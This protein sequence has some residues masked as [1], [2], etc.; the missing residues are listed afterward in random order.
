MQVFT[1]KIFTSKETQISES[2]NEFT[3][4]MAKSIRIDD[5]MN[6]LHTVIQ[7][8]IGLKKV[9]MCLYNGESFTIVHSNSPL[10]NNSINLNL[11][12]PLIRFFNT[13]DQCLFMRDFRRT[14]GYKSMWEKEKSELDNLSIECFYPLKDGDK[15]IGIIFLTA[16]ANNHRFTYN[17][18]N[19]LTSVSSI[20][21]IA[22]NNSRLYE[23]VLYEAN[24]DSLTGLLNRKRFFEVLNE[25]Y[26]KNK[27][28]SLALVIVNVDDFKLYNQLYGN[29]EGDKALQQIA[30]IIEATVGYDGHV[31]RYGGK[32]FAIILPRYDC[33]SA[34]NIANSIKNQILE[35]NKFT[36]NHSLKAIT[37]SVG[38]S[39]IP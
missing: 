3:A 22:I 14:I 25:E 19:F 28:H 23:K 29:K 9:F 24:V 35:V 1:N 10:D 34:K 20:G 12:H 17:D 2:L 37:I 26:H 8:T 39:S 21:S 27:D 16:K 6:S 13:S 4:F 15:L 7:N 38:I 30:S 32:E 11:D 18:I 31:A 5:I 36:K 33:L